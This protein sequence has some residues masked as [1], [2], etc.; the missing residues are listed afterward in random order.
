MF[1]F[2][3]TK[4]LQRRVESLERQLESTGTRLQQLECDH[5][6]TEFGTFYYEYSG[7]RAYHEFC[8]DCKKTLREFKSKKEYQDAVVEKAEATLEAEKA[9]LDKL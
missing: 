9:K 8:L 2:K 7:N 6:K 5:T 1:W 4:E 3:K